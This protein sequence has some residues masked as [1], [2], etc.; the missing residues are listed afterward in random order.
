ME[1]LANHNHDVEIPA[2]FFSES[3]RRQHGLNEE[4]ANHESGRGNDIRSSG[5]IDTLIFRL[6]IELG[7]MP[8]TES[9]T[10]G[11]L[12]DYLSIITKII[13]KKDETATLA[14]DRLQKLFAESTST[15]DEKNLAHLFVESCL[16]SGHHALLM[17]LACPE[18]RDEQILT[19]FLAR[20]HQ[21]HGMGAACDR[22]IEVL[23]RKP[24]AHYALDSL[25]P[26]TGCEYALRAVVAELS[27]NG[28]NE[29]KKALDS[30]QKNAQ[31]RARLLALAA[32]YYAESNARQT[33]EVLQALAQSSHP[34]YLALVMA[35]VKSEA[36]FKLAATLL[37][38]SIKEGAMHLCPAPQQVQLPL[39]ELLCDFIK[40]RASSYARRQ[41][42]R[43]LGAILSAQQNNAER[44]VDF[45]AG[46]RF[47]LG[48]AQDIADPDRRTARNITR[49][50]GLVF[51]IPGVV[52]RLSELLNGEFVPRDTSISLSAPEG[53]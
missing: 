7:R 23:L 8:N 24:C 18:G 15:G 35:G 21:L 48:R 20:N 31:M 33:K 42:I 3:Y 26:L 12:F 14:I 16:F 25:Q 38:E 37:L 29:P 22:A 49:D 53:L 5:Q 40:A 28:E 46:V 30:G 19:E 11:A 43:V 27:A 34:E 50:L 1:F 9:I 2:H 51:A 4:S 52:K 44:S 39:I 32:I 13:A 10:S 41:T 36:V 45:D 47:L 17:K 6:T